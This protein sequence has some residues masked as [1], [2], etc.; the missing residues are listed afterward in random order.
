MWYGHGGR[1]RPLGWSRQ[2]VLDIL[3]HIFFE[4]LLTQHCPSHT[5]IGLRACRDHELVR[6][7]QIMLGNGATDRWRSHSMGA[8]WRM[9][10]RIAGPAGYGHL[11]PD[12]DQALRDRLE[13]LH[14]LSQ[15]RPSARPDGPETDQATS[16]RL[17]GSSE[18][19]RHMA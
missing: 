17:E 1:I 4:N 3:G 12:P 6:P 9:C 15:T 11:D 18:P 7:R 14:A 10:G 19:P 16:S 2:A 8:P 5:S 13:A